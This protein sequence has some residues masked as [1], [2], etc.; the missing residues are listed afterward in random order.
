ML[1]DVH[2]FHPAVYAG[3]AIMLFG[4]GIVASGSCPLS[5]IGQ[6]RSDVKR[7]LVPPECGARFTQP[8]TSGK[9]LKCR[10]T[11]C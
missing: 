8:A 3:V 6:V 7:L 11:P 2:A 1:F 5:S 4:V 9:D 10:A